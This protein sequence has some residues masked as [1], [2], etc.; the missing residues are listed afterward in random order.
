MS[1]APPRAS[2]LARAP[3]AIGAWLVRERWTIAV[4]LAALVV[5]LH[6]NLRVHPPA[7]YVYSD[8]NGYVGR[9]AGLYND[10]F[11]KRE[12]SG[13]YPWG[14]H[15]LMYGIQKLLGKGDLRAVG[16]V[17]AVFSALTAMFGYLLARRV[18]RHAWVAPAVGL[19]LIF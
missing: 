4:L 3:R 7:D 12:Y 14:T 8:M 16:L 18:S 5:R 19:V 10:L 17:F 11:G 15:V 13:F 9:A 2:K 6:W 1:E